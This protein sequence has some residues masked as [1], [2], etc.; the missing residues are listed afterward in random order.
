MGVLSK[1]AKVGI[2][3]LLGILVLTYF[4]LRIGKMGVTERGYP[5]FASFDT[6][7]GLDEKSVVKMS[8]VPI[9]QVELIT[10]RDGRPRVRM[11]IREGVK[12]PVDSSISL[13]SEGLL[14]EKYVEI[15]PGRSREFIPS[16]GEIEKSIS[17]AT[18]DE[19]IRKVTLIADDVKKVTASLAEVL[20]SDD[21]KASLKEI[22]A[23]IR[24]SVKTL[25]SILSDNEK[26][27]AAILDNVERIT[28]D[29]K[30]VTGNEKEDLKA[31]IANLKEF[32]ETL[33]EKTPQLAA[34]LDD[35]LG[36]IE[37]MVDENRENIKQ[38]IENIKKASAKLDN[39]LGKIERGEGTLGKLVTEDAA[40]ENLN[41]T[42]EGINRYLKRAEK[43]QFYLDY[44]MEYL[45][46]PSEF[47]HYAALR[48]QPTVDKYYLIGVVDDPF[49][50]EKRT[51]T[52]TSTTDVNPP[53][54]TTTVETV[55]TETLDTLKFNALVA[56][57][58]GD[59]TFKGG[60]IESTGGFGLA[61]HAFSD[62]LTLGIEA[63]DFG[64]ED[65]DPHL[66]IYGN[67]DIFKN[68]FITA[69]YDDF[70]NND[71]DR[72]TIFVGFG[73]KFRDEDMK[74]LLGAAPPVTP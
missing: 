50:R 20:G 47:K 70:L 37:G 2:F 43:M 68:L 74:T 45:Q 33:K 23:N 30:D 13:A 24:E 4:T 22:V 39:T 15:V 69:G 44:R 19:L 72:R 71:R 58:F 34:K 1:E 38:A 32:S 41:S 40:Y 60:L 17:A 53:G 29:L 56:K 11:R 67:Y 55:K 35:T 3:L 31:L 7:A 61:Y 54:G 12:I 52:V 16:G 73:L 6:V 48:I 63:Y 27:V 36:N 51:T 49:G 14:G 10:L 18:L 64:R 66:K 46:E 62:S 57:R 28:A 5:V 21:G 25:R 9:G 42:L 65:D 26:K 8:G 59:F